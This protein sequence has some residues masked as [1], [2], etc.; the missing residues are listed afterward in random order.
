MP[1]RRES[2]R[3]MP[4]PETLRNLERESL[5][6][7]FYGEPAILVEQSL[8]SNYPW[9]LSKNRTSGQIGFAARG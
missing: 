1:L 2:V 4:G 5:K 6:T 8:P 3:S 7:E 9:S